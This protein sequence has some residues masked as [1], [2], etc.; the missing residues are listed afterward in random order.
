[1]VIDAAPLNGFLRAIFLGSLMHRESTTAS[2]PQS[3]LPLRYN[4]AQSWIT[5]QF[6]LLKK[7]PGKSRDFESFHPFPHL[8][9]MDTRTFFSSLSFSSA[10]S[11]LSSTASLSSSFLSLSSPTPPVLSFWVSIYER[12]EVKFCTPQWQQYAVR[13]SSASVA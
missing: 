6:C 9:V 5:L 3:K 4:F 10:S 7:R 1:M 2:G 11:S 8:N 12:A 13:P